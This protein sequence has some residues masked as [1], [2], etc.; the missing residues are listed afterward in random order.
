[1]LFKATSGKP[2]ESKACA[3]GVGGVLFVDGWVG[4]F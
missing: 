2:S 1:M 3:E 4:C